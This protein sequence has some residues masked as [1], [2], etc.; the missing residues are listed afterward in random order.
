M[1]R[2]D[3]MVYNKSKIIADYVSGLSLNDLNQKY[4]ITISYASQIM[5]AAG[6]NR[7]ISE[8]VL[9]SKSNQV[10]W[11]KLAKLNNSVTRIIS[12]PAMTLQEMGFDVNKN[13]LGKWI[14]AK[15]KLVLEIKEDDSS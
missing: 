15:D 5:R 1:K 6:V 10:E 4:G 14:I 12:I 13:L 7:S 9:L 11:H 2:S 3:E 8:A